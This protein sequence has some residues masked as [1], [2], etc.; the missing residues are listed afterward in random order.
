LWDVNADS[1]VRW[2]RNGKIEYV[3]LF[4]DD[5]EWSLVAVSEQGII[6]ELW[7]SWVESFEDEE[8]FKNFAHAIGFKHYKE[9]MDVWD[10]G[11]DEFTEWKKSLK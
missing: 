4:H 5:P 9:A 1:Y 8:E 2:K 6:A 10:K 11:Y 7:T 3:W